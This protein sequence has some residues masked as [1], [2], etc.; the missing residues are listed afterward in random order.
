MVFHVYLVPIFNTRKWVSM[1]IVCKKISNTAKCIK[2]DN[3]AIGAELT[4]QRSDLTF[5]VKGNHDKKLLIW[6]KC[7]QIWPQRLNQVKVLVGKKM[8]ICQKESK[9]I[10]WV[11]IKASE[12]WTFQIFNLASEVKLDLGGQSS[13]WSK[14]VYWT[15]GLCKQKIVLIS[16]IVPELWP[17]ESVNLASEVKFDLRGQNSFRSKV[18]YLS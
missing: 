17:F 18:A 15:K 2:A 16:I 9:K 12:L 1:R 8:R 14:L 3:S 10:F 6:P 11:C 13:F 4:S 7:W 5:E